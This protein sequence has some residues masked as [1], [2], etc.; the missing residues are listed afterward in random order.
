MRFSYKAATATV[1]SGDTWNVDYR[2]PL[3]RSGCLTLGRFVRGITG[4]EPVL[5]RLDKS[6]I[7][8]GDSPFAESEVAY[9]KT[10]APGAIICRPDQYQTI[11]QFCAFL[12]T[13]GILRVA[14][15]DPVAAAEFV[16][17][18]ARK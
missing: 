5:E 9:L 11:S 3:C 2:G 4:Y 17:V 12:A 6:V 15:L 7:L 14:F 8:T 13:C 10:T 1:D 18:F 16:R